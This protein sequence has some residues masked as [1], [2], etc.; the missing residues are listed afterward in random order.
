MTK[1]VYVTSLE[2]LSG[3]D[4][5]A[6]SLVD[7][8]KRTGASAEIFRAIAKDA[9]AGCSTAALHEDAE[10]ALA[11]VVKNHQIAAKTTDVVVAVGSDY[12]DASTLGEF[13]VN[14]EAA[15]C[16]NA[17]LVLVVAAQQASA[18]DLR[19]TIEAAL[20]RTATAHAVVMSVVLYGGSAE[21]AAALSDLVPT[22]AVN[23]SSLATAT[24]QLAEL[25]ANTVSTI[26]TPLAFQQELQS[27]AAANKKTIVLPEASDDRIL[28]TAAIVTKRG[29]ADII[30]LG[31]SEEILAR[32]A[33][34]GWDLSKA[35]IISPKDPELLE[36][37][38]TKYAELRAKKGVT[39]EQAREKFT[40]LSYFGTMMIYFDMADGMVSGA[41]NT[42]ANTIKPSFEFIKTKP[43]TKVVSSSFMMCMPDEVLVFGDCAVNPN[44]T[45]EELADIALGCAKTA[46][47]FG[48]EPRVAML[49]YSTVDSGKGPDVDAV[50]EATRIVKELA[51][52]LKLAG[53]I[54]FDAA[55]DPTVGAKKMP[56][57]P[58]AGQATVYVFPDLNTGNNT[59]KAVQRTSGALAIGPVLQG[60]NKP[61]NDL[62]R[63]ALVDDIVN[64]VAITAIQAQ[65]DDAIEGASK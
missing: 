38:S 49:S 52:D 35:K 22:I 63:G 43:G 59:Y 11:S 34:K 46:A 56:G 15:A 36:K 30:L 40:D 26:R 16:L 1:T 29:F 42:T 6:L 37:F 10:A 28:E 18:A 64:T 21:T 19:W 25:A 60:L 3:K 23:E 51:P 61:V 14:A 27:I 41:I 54:Q 5:V 39:I 58:V 33:A 55:M 32:A 45:P 62:S 57:S 20:A 50:I 9:A 17:P 4:A 48:I 7:S 8:F 12:A 44:P 47:R 65:D 2:A 24:D 53:P 31:E 13:E